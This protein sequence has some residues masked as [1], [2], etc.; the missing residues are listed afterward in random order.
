MLPPLRKHGFALWCSCQ[1]Y[2][3]SHSRYGV[4]PQRRSATEAL[5]PAQ[6]QVRCR[7]KLC[8]IGEKSVS[9][10]LKWSDPDT[11]PHI[12]TFW[13]YQQSRNCQ[14][15]LLHGVSNICLEWNVFAML[16]N[17][18]DLPSPQ[19][20]L[21]GRSRRL[22]LQS[23]DFSCRLWIWSAS[24]RGKWFFFG[25]VPFSSILQRCFV[26]LVASSKDCREANII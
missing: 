18:P 17:R 14:L 8:F 20:L 13:I 16:H 26:Y 6:L 22:A 10:K 1:A 21:A 11:S 23:A 12:L 25:F 5:S 2:A 4:T 3:C 7:S 15:V 9:V 24:T 19:F